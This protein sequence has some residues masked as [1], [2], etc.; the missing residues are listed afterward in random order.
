[1]VGD[2][3]TG[4]DPAEDGVLPVEPGRL[5]RRHDEELRTVRVR[6]GVCHR[7]VSARDA[8]VVEL[9]LERVART[10]R[11]VTARTAALDHEVRDDAVEDE[12]VVVA[13]TGELREI[14][15]RLR[16]VVV[17]ELELDRPLT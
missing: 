16:S 7:E 10:A 12:A 17:E 14:R 8:M 15:N 3:L 9:V 13:V 1:L 11:A 6:P 5:V 2:V 4:C